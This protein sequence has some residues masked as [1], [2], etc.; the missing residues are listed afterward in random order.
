MKLAGSNGTGVHL[1]YCTNIHRG[2]SWDETR[3]ALRRH[4]PEVK[5]LVAPQQKMGVGLRLSALASSER[6]SRK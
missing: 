6:V 2:E 3:A 1:T 5:R 4:L